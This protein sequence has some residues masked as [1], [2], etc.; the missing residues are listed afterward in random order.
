MLLLKT[1]CPYSSAHPPSSIQLPIACAPSKESCNCPSRRRTPA[2]PGNLSKYFIHVTSTGSS[3]YSSARSTKLRA[4]DEED[5]TNNI[6][7]RP[8]YFAWVVASRGEE[9]G[10]TFWKKNH[11]VFPLDFRLVIAPVNIVKYC[12]LLGRNIHISISSCPIQNI[13]QCTRSTKL[14]CRLSSK[15]IQIISLQF[16]TSIQKIYTC[17]FTQALKKRWKSRRPKLLSFAVFLAHTQCLFT[18]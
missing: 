5:N 8:I 17:A 1:F 3:K 10:R 4:S 18:I 15:T 12:Q 2:Q 9:G 6:L 14:T 13:F 16:K 11:K 7:P